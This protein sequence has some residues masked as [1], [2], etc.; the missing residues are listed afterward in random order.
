MITSNGWAPAAAGA[1]L[2]LQLLPAPAGV[3]QEDFS[4]DPNTR[5]WQQFCDPAAFH[6]DPSSQ[7]LE[8]TWDSTRPNSY[9]FHTLGTT[10]AMDDDFS[11]AF[12]LRLS[13]IASGVAPSATGPFEIAIGFLDLAVATNGAFQRGVFG[14]PANLVEFDY[15]P[16]G[17]Y[18]TPGGGDYFPVDPTVSP[19]LISSNN[20][21][22]TSFT[23]PLELT[24]NDLFHVTL[25]YTASNQT[26][27]TTLLRNG[28]P[29]SPVQ[30][31]VAG[32]GFGDFRVDAVSIS[33]Y[34]DAGDPYDSVRAH[35]VVDNVV[36][37]VP[38]GPRLTGAFV[39]DLWQV[40]VVSRTNWVEVLER[41]A[42]LTRWDVVSTAQPGTGATLVLIETNHPPAGALFYRASGQRP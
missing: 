37:T 31:T 9:F 30:N 34:S 23:T 14:N 19:T 36:V 22:A 27:A 39:G 16:A 29:Y 6:W 35:G 32:P 2:L 7:S 38:D 10:L 21:F 4:S 1:L 5:G 25:T 41:S 24:L 12:D 15:F 28:Q 33:S 42:D 18:G 40:E 26:L 3:I 20:Q 17:Y 13:D 11:L 8:V